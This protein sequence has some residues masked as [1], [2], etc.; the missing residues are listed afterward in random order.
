MR[1]RQNRD[2]IFSYK[3]QIPLSFRTKHVKVDS[4]S[5]DSDND[6]AFQRVH[7][8]ENERSESPKTRDSDSDQEGNDIW[9]TNDKSLEEMNSSAS[10]I[11][12]VSFTRSPSPPPP[13]PELSTATL[14]RI[15]QRQAKNKK[16]R[17]LDNVLDNLKKSADNTWS[18]PDSLRPHSVINLD[19]SYG[20]PSPSERNI[21]VKVRTRSGIKRFNMKA[22]EPFG[23]IISALARQEGVT[24]DKIMLSLSDINI[25]G[26]DT[27]ISIHLS[28]ADIIEC[29]V[30]DT[31]VVDKMEEDEENKIEIKVQGND[32]DSKKTFKVLKTDPLEKLMTAY[33][34]FRKLPR[35][36]LK[37]SFDGEVL[38]GGETPDQLDMEDEDVIDVRVK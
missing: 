38:K 15:H 7:S 4:D 10:D 8:E 22:A 20:L 26:Y 12:E 34:E 1:K 24:E 21:T 29:V 9:V 27:P 14:I 2:D 36:R 17:E 3:G 6:E 37:F 5:S 31:P 25:L 16:L 18:S 28:V 32:A 11:K 23:Q 35:S 33:C 30:V 19:D 13:C